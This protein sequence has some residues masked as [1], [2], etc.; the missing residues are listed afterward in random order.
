MA[1]S[2]YVPEDC[3]VWPQWEKV[4]RILYKLDAPG[5]EDA[6]RHEECGWES[7]GATSQKQMGG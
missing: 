2:T 4:P 1:P 3:I 5:K 7:G 6:G